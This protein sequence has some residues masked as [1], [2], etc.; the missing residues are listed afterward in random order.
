MQIIISTVQGFCI[1]FQ[2]SIY[3]FWR[4]GEGYWPGPE[5]GE[6]GFDNIWHISYAGYCPQ[7]N[8][9]SKFDDYR[10][11]KFNQKKKN[12]LEASRM[13]TSMTPL[14]RRCSAALSPENI[15]KLGE[16]CCEIRVNNHL[17][18]IPAPTIMTSAFFCC[19]CCWCIF[20]FVEARS[21]FPSCFVDV[22]EKKSDD[23]VLQVLR[24]V[25][26]FGQI[27]DQTELVLRGSI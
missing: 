3:V 9:S 21:C 13:T 26:V 18:D 7:A 12:L 22:W 10:Q 23:P 15:S 16:M 6:G 19:C 20:F 8:N 5:I 17:P 24:V 4:I 14:R 1:R 27:G 25:V 11:N 2:V